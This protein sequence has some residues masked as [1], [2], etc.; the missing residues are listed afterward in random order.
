MKLLLLLL[1]LGTHQVSE[2][3][4][5]ANRMWLQGM[6][7]EA[8][9]RLDS[10]LKLFRL[11]TRIDA[12]FLPAHL[13]Y[14]HLM[15]KQGRGLQLRAE[16][17]RERS[18]TPL[19][20]CLSTA[21]WGFTSHDVPEVEKRYRQLIRLEGHT[22][23]SEA[24]QS[25]SSVEDAPRPQLI[26]DAITLYGNSPIL[27][28]AYV[29]ALR[30][31]GEKESRRRFYQSAVASAP[32]TALA[33]EYRANLVGELITSGNRPGA[34]AEFQRLA[35][36]FRNDVRPFLRWKLLEREPDALAVNDADYLVRFHAAQTAMRAL[37]RRSGAIAFEF[38]A[39]VRDALQNIDH[40]D[41]RSA[42][43]K[44]DEAV[45]LAERAG[46]PRF[47]LLAYLARGRA[48]AAQGNQSAAVADLDKAARAA[49]LLGERYRL[50][51]SYHHMAHAYEARSNWPQ[52]MAAI[53]SFV[54]VA[55]TAR[56]R[57]MRMIRW[58][59]AGNI[60]WKAGHHA[61]ANA[62]YLEMVRVIEMDSTHYEYAAAYFER[63]GDLPRAAHYYRKVFTDSRQPSSKKLAYAG[64]TRVYEELGLVDSAM[65][66]ARSHDALVLTPEREILLPKLLYRRGNLAEARRLAD[67]WAALQLDRGNPSAYSAAL[68]QQAELVLK[69]QPRRAIALAASADSVARQVNSRREIVDAR[70]LRGMAKA[71]L[72]DAEAGV[73]D[74]L[75]ALAMAGT[76]QDV[77]LPI[78]LETDIA[79]VWARAGRRELALGGYA[80]ADLA[81]KSAARNFDDPVAL[82]QLRSARRAVFDGAIRTA[83]SIGGTERVERLLEWSERKKGG[84]SST[85]Q[86]QP[87]P[88]IGRAIVDYLTVGDTLI[89][90]VVTHAG[91]TSRILPLSARATAS[92]T[93]ALIAPL[94]EIRNGRVDISRAGY[95]LA[96]A[97][98]L[99]EGLLAPLEPSLAGA[100]S[101][102]IVPDVP[103]QL[104][105]FEALV[106]RAPTGPTTAA[107][108]STVTYVADK[109]TVTFAPTT[110][111]AR[112]AS[113][114]PSLAGSKIVFV[115]NTA[116]GVERERSAIRSIW[117][118][119]RLSELVGA[120][121]TERR[122]RQVPV[123]GIVHFASHSISDDVDPL[124]SH[125]TLV[126]EDRDDGLL[127]GA[128]IRRLRW[129]GALIF[130]SACET[131][132]GP[133]FAGTGTLS[134]ARAFLDGGAQ[135]V[136]ATQWPVGETSAELARDFYRSLQRGAPAAAALHRA[137]LAV[138][139]DPRTAHPFY[140]ASHVLISGA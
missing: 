82:A 21:A 60:Y 33:F 15:E 133:M 39:L 93:A 2:T 5:S 29:R 124:R 130:L 80:R 95:S 126:A 121:A 105:P 94:R 74:L 48:L 34:A 30:L 18:R 97:R 65:A 10:A 104:V 1:F 28:D 135:T 103:L 46:S 131:A 132:S 57:A 112:K 115:A 40:G 140:W 26:R 134:L 79:D 77:F 3:R 119:S 11:A 122:V 71:G 43:R 52:A 90:T 68:N 32:T 16:Y 136:I 38:H 56:D 91:A 13:S 63:I 123:S 61:R 4:S 50:A 7:R 62:F 139:R 106:A 116:P 138:R 125:L 45:A 101:V 83:L 41:L 113:P 64:L 22:P 96:I 109:W 36:D 47:R 55:A 78:T 73:R 100:T 87:A 72:G 120:H 118:A 111:A 6:D 99:Y 84:R 17:D 69:E 137:K 42:R 70:R 9:F 107:S 128:E 76:L 92:R 117:P 35:S 86:A 20:R 12:Q 108:Y 89:A 58:N 67:Q 53:D 75:A 110:R 102:T 51:D 27:T 19:G 114:L 81:L 88:A 66:T 31:T 49:R 59:D 44:L 37:A 14:M 8:E 25:W 85:E 23:C 127:H 98:E 24:I 54:S 129:P